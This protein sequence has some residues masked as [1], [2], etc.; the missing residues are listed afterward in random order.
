MV[1]DLSPRYDKNDDY[2]MHGFAVAQAIAADPQTRGI[3]VCG[4]GEG[5][6]MAANRIPGARALVGE[7]EA[8]IK[9]ARNDEDA[10][11]LALSGWDL[12]LPR[13][14]K[15]IRVFLQTPASK[16]AR[17]RRRIEELDQVTQNPLH[18]PLRKGESLT[19]MSPSLRRRG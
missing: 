7:Q 13:A 8:S 16:A 5:I 11:I 9:R 12:S 6:S 19:V 14:M 2:P 15:L 18:L 10:N 3:L 1:Q 17:H 4:S